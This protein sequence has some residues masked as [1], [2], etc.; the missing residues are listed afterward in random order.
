MSGKS[1]ADLVQMHHFAASTPDSVAV[2]IGTIAKS[3][4]TANEHAT[5]VFPELS[6]S[7]IIK[8]SAEHSMHRLRPNASKLSGRCSE[9]GIER[10]PQ[11]TGQ[12]LAMLRKRAFPA[13]LSTP[14]HYRLPSSRGCVIDSPQRPAVSLLEDMAVTNGTSPSRPSHDLRPTRSVISLFS[15]CG[16]MDL[17]FLGG[18]KF[19][20]HHYERLPFD[21]IWAND[22][23][24]SACATYEQNIGSNIRRGDV[25]DLMGT[26]PRTADVV[27]GGFPCQDVSINGVKSAAQ[28]ARTILYQH[29]IEVIQ[30]TNPA[31]F[32]AENVKGLLMSHGKAFFDK[33]L[34]DFSLPGYRLD[35]RL[36]LAADYGVPQ[37]RERI[38]FV[39]VR[40]DLQFE[41]PVPLQERITARDALA[42]LEEVQE[43]REIAHIWSKAKLSPE[44]GN[45]RLVADKPATT[46]RAEHHGN[47][48]WHYSLDRRISLREAARLQSF[49]DTFRFPAGMRETERQIG[50]AVPPV[51]AWHIANTVRGHLDATGI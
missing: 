51:L 39:G 32:V 8:L 34:Q 13:A 25:A 38:F 22:I 45:R 10:S 21:V 28:G 19:G 41:H 26:L 4:A 27:I 14:R 20:G 9:L 18:F 7:G 43:N 15:G 29:M 50:N 12:A 40:G 11:R 23:N 3:N 35:Y 48:Q 5:S 24:S 16:G 33:M 30:T 2:S 44:Q 17:G 36:Y 49:P 47:I 31:V 46:I 6:R 37:M 1:K 42:D